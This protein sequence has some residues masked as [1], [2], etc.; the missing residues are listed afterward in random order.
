MKL[1]AKV[2]YGSILNEVV[3]IVSFVTRYN[4]TYAVAIRRD[5]SLHNY[6]IEDLIVIDDD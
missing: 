4:S 2:K 3:I 5:G 1:K 6:S